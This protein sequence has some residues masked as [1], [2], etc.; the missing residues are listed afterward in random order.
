MTSSVAGLMMAA[1]PP[2]TSFGDFSG[3]YNT[4]SSRYLVAPMEVH[5]SLFPLFL[6]TETGDLRF[7]KLTGDKSYTFGNTLLDF[8]HQARSLRFDASIV[9]VI[10]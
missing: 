6:R 8:S 9:S 2:T 10:S 3:A 4:V 7:L 5:G 1:S